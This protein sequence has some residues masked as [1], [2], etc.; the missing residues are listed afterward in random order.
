MRTPVCCLLLA[1][2]SLLI[3]GEK[4]AWEKVRVKYTKSKRVTMWFDY[5]IMRLH[6]SGDPE[7]SRY[8][9]G[10][11]IL[12]RTTD[13]PCIPNTRYGV[14]V[15]VSKPVLLRAVA[16]FPKSAK[17]PDKMKTY[18]WKDKAIAEAVNYVLSVG[19]GAPPGKTTI[20]LYVEDV[21]AKTIEFMV[22]PAGNTYVNEEKGFSIDLPEGW[23]VR[24]DS[25]AE[26]IRAASPKEGPDDKFC[27]T[28]SI[29]GMDRIGKSS[30]KGYREFTELV[31]HLFSGF[32][33]L[34]SGKTK[35]NKLTARWMLY[36][37]DRE[38]RRLTGKP[39]KVAKAKALVYF[40]VKGDNAF[41]INATAAEET[42]DQ[43]RPTFEQIIN[44][45]QMIEKK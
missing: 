34:D 37:C 26:G 45:F 3:G 1:T 15:K 10:S 12:K 40:V 5:G 27:E 6:Y 39:K 31:L 33:K 23:K 44:S 18:T 28:V 14:V 24:Q 25:D 13:V 35:I 43:Y 32:E 21:E 19:A 11:E 16:S 30:S 29:K 20:T 17:Q 7:L 36:T 41:M 42:F 8:V 22:V 9:A 2:T 38:R 4:Y